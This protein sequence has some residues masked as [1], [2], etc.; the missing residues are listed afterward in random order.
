MDPLTDVLRVTRTHGA[1]LARVVA[2]EP[3]GVDISG[4]PGA[5]VHVMTA[6]TAWLRTPSLPPRRLQPG[7]VVLLPGGKPHTLSS[8]PSG[9]AESFDRLAKQRLTTPDGELP[10]GRDQPPDDG[11]VT[12]FLCAG[13]DYDRSVAQQLMSALP[14]VVHVPAGTPGPEAVAVSAVLAL[15]LPELPGT[16]PGSAAAVD[17]LIDVLL[18]HVLRAWLR[19]H[20][21]TAASWLRGLGEP[22]TAKALTLLH[23]R[24]GHPWTADSIAAAVGVSRATLARRFTETVGRPPLGY[25][26]AWRMDLAS[27]ALRDTD[28][29]VEAVARSVGYTSEPA[30]TRAF[31][32]HRGMPPGRWRTQAQHA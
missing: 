30:F 26:T 31:A 3:W 4:T 11:A 5:A 19:A 27:Q 29:P 7:D 23:E 18:V 1:V 17:R 9:P 2:Q 20:P 6:G 8:A 32:R 12:R 16:D 14:D 21:A 22:V 25:L 24:P 15:L 10:L 13:Y 28:S